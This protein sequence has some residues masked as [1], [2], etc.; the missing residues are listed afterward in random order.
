MDKELAA[1]NALG[2]R[3]HDKNLWFGSLAA[4]AAAHCVDVASSWGK[5]EANGLLQ[6]QDGRF[7]GKSLAVKLGLVAGY[8]AIQDQAV[9]RDPALY[10]WMAGLNAVVTAAYGAV[11]ARNFTI[12]RK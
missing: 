5:H 8:V 2:A 4:L 7:D 10:R 11:A 3:E 9:L 1:I 6:G 12:P